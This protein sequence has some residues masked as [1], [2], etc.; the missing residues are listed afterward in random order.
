MNISQ[1]KPLQQYIEFCMVILYMYVSIKIF[2]GFLLHLDW[3]YCEWVTV[4]PAMN[5]LIRCQ[6]PVVQKLDSTIHHIQ[7]ISI[8]E[9]N[10][11]IHWTVIYQADRVIHILNKWA[12]VFCMTLLCA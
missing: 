7:W 3:R 9:T 1:V 5:L 4:C 6:A 8:R 11:T 2:L 10:Y 12:L